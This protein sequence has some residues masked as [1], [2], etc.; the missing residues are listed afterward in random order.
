MRI[1]WT[2]IPKVVNPSPAASWAD[3]DVVE[4]TKK[5]AA[6]HI[7]SMKDKKKSERATDRLRG[8]R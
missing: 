6:K 1:K 4:R 2:S 3:P 5:E 8:S 7:G